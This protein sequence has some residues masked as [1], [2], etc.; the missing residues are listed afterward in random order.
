MIRRLT[1]ILLLLL[2]GAAAAQEQLSL[3]DA[4]ARALEHNFDIRMAGVIATQA[5][6][7]NTAGNAGL[8]PDI[9]A[10]GGINAGNANT[11]IE[12]ADGRI[13][14]VN[15]AN[16]I[17]YTAGLT[18]NYT[19]F[20]G[21]RAFLL[22]KQLKESEA[23][24]LTQFKAQIQATVAQVVQAY[25][26]AVWQQQQGIAI[27]TGLALARTRMVLSLANYETGTAAKTDYLQA[28]VDYNARR[29]DSLAQLAAV[30]NAQAD[31]NTLMGEDPF[32]TYQVADSLMLDLS[33]SASDKEL[34]YT[35]N[36][37][38][39]AARRTIAWSKLNERIAR[40][41][42][43]PSLN[44]NGGYNF[45]RTQSQAGFAMFNQS[46]GPSGGLT[47]Q[48]PV[49]QGGNRNRELKTASLQV[50]RDELA[51]EKQYSETGRQYR[52]AWKDYEAGVAAYRLEKENIVFARENLA[53]QEARLRVGF[54]N[55]LEMREAE[56]S[57]IQALIRLYTAAYQLKVNET[58]VLELENKLVK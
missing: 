29:A 4:I 12:F 21:G 13:Q 39:D 40:T 56:N 46:Y 10:I 22:R 57:F 41:F 33:L 47:L 38:L 3:Q 31:L 36:L 11:R 16:T 28:R 23:I 6:V 25:A 8:L 55:T 32:T 20:A 27:D 19:L 54:A 26:L 5:T 45:S 43:L 34:L 35:H 49:F 18:L 48:I 51:Y 7:N 14:E 9:N 37:N 50:F 17:G 24:A 52:R 42:L 15:S 1:V 53:I 30:S 44:L 2:H 58:R